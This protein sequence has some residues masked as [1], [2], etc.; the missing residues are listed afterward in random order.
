[1]ENEMTKIVIEIKNCR[2]C[3]FFKT[4][5]H[6]STDAFDSMVDWICGKINEKIE[7]SIHI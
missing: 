6:Y 1:M 2:D 5:N 4:D 3:P 7:G